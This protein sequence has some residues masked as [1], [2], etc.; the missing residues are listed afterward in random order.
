LLPV[1]AVLVAYRWRLVSRRKLVAASVLA[2][3]AALCLPSVAGGNEIEF[4]AQ[5][6]FMSLAGLQYLWDPQIHGGIVVGNATVPVPFLTMTVETSP[7]IACTLGAAAN[8]VYWIGI[9]SCWFG[10]KRPGAR[11][12]ACR[13]ATFAII[14]ATLAIVVMCVDTNTESFYPGCGFWIASFLALALGTRD[15]STNPI[16]LAIP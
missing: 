5:L 1:V 11:R 6:A 15:A 9:A 3:I 16:G 12:F 2:Y 14:L 4:G 8:L 13:G 10:R 7:I